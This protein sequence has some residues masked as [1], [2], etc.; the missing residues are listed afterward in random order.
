MS[1]TVVADCPAKTLSDI[2][3]LSDQIVK[4]LDKRVRKPEEALRLQRLQNQRWELQAQLPPLTL[5]PAN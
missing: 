2:Y 4:L 1:L 3:K 5:V